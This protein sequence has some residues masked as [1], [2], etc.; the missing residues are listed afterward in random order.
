MRGELI[1][2]GEFNQI[3]VDNNCEVTYN[4]YVKHYF[5]DKNTQKSIF[6]ATKVKLIGKN[7]TAYTHQS[8]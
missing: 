3:R 8:V 1:S 6:R 7:V 4:P 5:F 2:E